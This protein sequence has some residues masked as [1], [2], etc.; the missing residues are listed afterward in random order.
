M[1]IHE[2]YPLKE[3][4]NINKDTYFWKKGDKLNVYYIGGAEDVYFINES[5][6]IYGLKFNWI[7]L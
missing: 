7:Y 4:M 3:Q 6:E 1:E 2:S 5:V